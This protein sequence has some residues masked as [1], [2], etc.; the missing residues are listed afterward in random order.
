MEEELQ[1]PELGR[2]SPAVCGDYNGADTHAE[3]H[4]LGRYFLKETAVCG[5]SM[6]VPMGKTHDGGG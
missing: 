5:K 6:S 4:R 2:G 1:V 3:S